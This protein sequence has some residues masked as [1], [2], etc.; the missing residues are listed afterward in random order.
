M[1]VPQIATFKL[2]AAP[3]ATIAHGSA[4]ETLIVANEGKHVQSIAGV[5]QSYMRVGGRCVLTRSDGSKWGKITPSHFKLGPNT[6][7]EVHVALTVPHGAKGQHDLL[8]SFFGQVPGHGSVHVR[9]SVGSLLDV[10]LPGKSNACISLS[11]PVTHGGSPLVAIIIG[12][13]VVAVLATVG[14]I[15]RSRRNRRNKSVVS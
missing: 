15:L 7:R 2:A 9:G 3:A 10:K 4:H 6:S 14:V 13:A 11:A 8:A 1:P 12:V 5:M